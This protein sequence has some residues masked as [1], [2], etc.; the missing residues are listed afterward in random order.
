[1]ATKTEWFLGKGIELLARVPEGTY[2]DTKPNGLE[3]QAYDLAGLHKI[4]A[5]FP[6]VT[7]KKTWHRDLQWWEYATEYEGVMLRIYAVRESP[8]KCTARYETREVEEQVPLTYTTRKVVKEV[9][10][11]WDCVERYPN[12][13]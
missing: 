12:E 7:W 3:F 5:S 2:F 9:L 10:I 1:M 11:G 13:T 8:A 6:G 4:T